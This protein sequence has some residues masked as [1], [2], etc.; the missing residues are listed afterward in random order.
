M[1]HAAPG[2]VNGDQARRAGRVEDHTRAAHRKHVRQTRAGRRV[3]DASQIIR[4]WDTWYE[5]LGVHLHHASENARVRVHQRRAVLS[6]PMERLVAHFEQHPLLRLQWAGLGG[7]DGEH[8][9]VEHGE[10][11][12]QE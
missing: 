3:R 9:V 7:R 4:S 2:N 8:G 10:V 6:L 1:V 12:L 5:L 11:A